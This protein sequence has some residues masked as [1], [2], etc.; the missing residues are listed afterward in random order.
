MPEDDKPKLYMPGAVSKTEQILSGDPEEMAERT[1]QGQLALETLRKS[2]ADI[3]RPYE[4]LMLDL[5]RINDDPETKV[6]TKITNRPFDLLRGLFDKKRFTNMVI[7]DSYS[8]S[9]DNILDLSYDNRRHDGLKIASHFKYDE[10]EW[11]TFIENYHI[12]II[13]KGADGLAGYIKSLDIYFRDNKISQITTNRIDPFDGGLLLAMK[14]RRAEPESHVPNN[15][16]SIYYKTFIDI[17]FP[18]FANY[19]NSLQIN[20]QAPIPF[21][22]FRTQNAFFEYD[23]ETNNFIRAMTEEE[24]EYSHGRLERYNFL[25][26]E[27]FLGSL[28]ELLYLVPATPQAA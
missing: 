20:L 18:R 21:L 12:D 8:W 4:E 16:V 28:E 9:W 27:H 13:P 3:T 24:K 7:T 11:H 14:A 2:I 10:I 25:T 26:A 19:E 5:A 15:S 1:I 22:F 17:P 23:P 6:S